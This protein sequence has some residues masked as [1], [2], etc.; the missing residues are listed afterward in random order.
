MSHLGVQIVIGRLLTDDAFRQR[1][2]EDRSECLARARQYGIDLDE[3]E[4]SALLEADAAL[5]TKMAARIDSRLRHGGLRANARAPRV[6]TARERRV[7]RGVIDGLT[8]K[9]IGA[10]VGASEGAVKATLQ[11]LFRK[12]QVRTRAQLVRVALES[13]LLQGAR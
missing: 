2:E 7:L 11:H 5:W 3:G 13:R 9:Q 4:A 1:F 6:L 12:L 10:D 8:N